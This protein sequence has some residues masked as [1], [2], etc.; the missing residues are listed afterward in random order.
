M[1][2][3]KIKDKLSL[4][5]VFTVEDLYTVDPDFRIETLYDWEAKGW[6]NRLRNKNYIFSDLK[7]SNYDL[8]LVAN[9]LYDPSYVSLEMALNH[10]GVIPEMVARITSITTN[11]TLSVETKIGTF[12][13]RT[14]D[15]SLFFGYKLITIGGVTYK[16]A[17]LEKTIADYLYLNPQ[18]VAVEDIQG[19]RF[20]ETLLREKLN[21]DEL[22]KTLVVFDNKALSERVRVLLN[23]LKI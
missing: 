20:N 7:L 23:Y 15:S 8:Y 16:I 2:Y 14:V 4:L 18:I 10:Y 17:S 1:K 3:Y 6:V 21:R 11:K 9:K 5:K 12:D 13:Y 22:E 19:L